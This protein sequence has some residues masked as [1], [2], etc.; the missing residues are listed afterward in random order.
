MIDIWVVFTFCALCFLNALEKSIVTWE[1]VYVYV[2]GM[3]L[4]VSVYGVHL[5]VTAFGRH[6]FV[7]H[8]ATKVTFLKLSVLLRALR[9]CSVSFR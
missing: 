8:S 3:D 4:C 1:S 2:G 7:P 5:H 9:W 6:S